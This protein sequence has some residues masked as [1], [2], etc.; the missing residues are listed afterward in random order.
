MQPGDSAFGRGRRE[1]RERTVELAYEAAV[2]DLTVDEMLATLVLPA[3]PFTVE[4][5][6]LAEAHREEADRLISKRATGWTLA[7]MP[8][9]DLIIMRLA[10]AELIEGITPTGVVLSEAVEL[11]GRYSTDESS[12][13]VNGVLG[14]RRDR[15]GRYGGGRLGALD[16][17][18]E[19]AIETLTS[20]VT[21]SIGRS[22]SAP[23]I[24][25]GCR[26]RVVVRTHVVR[27]RRGGGEL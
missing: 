2:R 26:R 20:V 17:G 11:A 21:W 3:P 12:R 18:P 22:A 27:R 6:R 5:L 24:D 8:V 14:R 1:S 7:R 9:L 10:V 25:P 23:V 15:S 16:V 13:F 4:L 19:G